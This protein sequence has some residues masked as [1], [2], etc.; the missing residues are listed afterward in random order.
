MK[1]SRWYPAY[2]G[3]GSNLESPV[4]QV[5]RGI[6]TLGK[7]DNSI[8][9]ACSGLY[10]SKPVG[11]IEQPDFINAVASIL[12]Q[13]PARKLLDALQAI[14]LDHGRVRDG[15]RWGPRTLDLDLLS[16]GSATLDDDRLVLPHPRIRE[17][18]FVLLPWQEIAPHYFV[19]GLATVSEL[20]QNL[21][22][23]VSGIVKL[24]AE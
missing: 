24:G 2:I 16:Y 13:L 23:D 1:R 4:D 19:P 21:G 18:L 14:E 11:L 8:L 9:V 7:I 17:R 10:C 6:E 3:I 22:D 20:T 15:P 5:E 12:T